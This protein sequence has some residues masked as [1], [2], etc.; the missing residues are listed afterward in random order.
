M[1]DV[2]WCLFGLTIVFVESWAHGSY[3]WTAFGG[4]MAGFYVH[5]IAT[6]L[7]KRRGVHGGD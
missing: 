1:G 2:G 5:R 3:L 7:D 6:V 4:F